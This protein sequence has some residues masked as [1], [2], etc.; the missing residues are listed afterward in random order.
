MNHLL[1]P[2]WVA[3]CGFSPSHNHAECSGRTVCAPVFSPFR[4]STDYLPTHCYFVTTGNKSFR[5]FNCQR[6]FLIQ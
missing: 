3:C 6:S 4:S 2:L 1:L 5:L